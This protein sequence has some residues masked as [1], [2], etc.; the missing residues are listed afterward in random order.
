M[1]YH[2]RFQKNCV[3]GGGFTIHISELLISPIFLPCESLSLLTA[4]IKSH[5]TSVQLYSIRACIFD[6][7]YKQ[8]SQK[9]WHTNRFNK[10][11]IN[12]IECLIPSSSISVYPLDEHTLQVLCSFFWPI[13]CLLDWCDVRLKVGG[14]FIC[15]P[16]P[17]VT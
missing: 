5:I 16:S 8:R 7:L 12:L 10:M 6:I 11:C 14:Q 3:W 1:F 9:S 2:C 17:V 4:V 15:L 13:S